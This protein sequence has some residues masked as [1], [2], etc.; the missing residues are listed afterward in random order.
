M[1][2]GPDLQGL[3]RGDERIA[4]AERDP[5]RGDDQV[6][7]VGGQFEGGGGLA[8][9]VADDAKVE[10][11]PAQ[12]PDGGGQDGRVGVPDLPGGWGVEG[13]DQ[14]IAGGQDGHPGPLA[15]PDPHAAKGRHQADLEGAQQVAL[16]QDRGAFLHVAAA[17]PHVA[18]PRGS[19]AEG[20]LAVVGGDLDVLDLDDGVG[21]GGQKAARGDVGGVP[22]RQ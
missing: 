17:V 1:H 22:G 10:G 4:A 3:E 11:F 6:G 18:P 7:E 8:G 19:R 15:D 5:A 21:P 20:H 2:D 12:L 14:L 16:P 9:V 13:H